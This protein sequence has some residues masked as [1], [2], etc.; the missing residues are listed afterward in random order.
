MRRFGEGPAAH[1]RGF[2]YLLS[3]HFGDPAQVQHQAYQEADEGVAE[4]TT[5]AVV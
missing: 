3:P 2:T 5:V 1:L 4:G